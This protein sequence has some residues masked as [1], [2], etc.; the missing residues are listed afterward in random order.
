MDSTEIT[1][2]VI[3]VITIR[4]LVS[5]GPYSGES[6][7]PMYG[8][9]EAQR[10][11]MEITINTPVTEWYKDTPSND[12][13]YWGLDYPPLTAYHSWLCGQ[14]GKLI[15][16][17]WVT[18]LKSRGYESIQHKLFM[19]YSVLVVDLMIYIPAVIMFYMFCGSTDKRK[20]TKMALA[21]LLYP[22]VIL[23]DYG[24]FQYN[25]VSL[26][27]MI[28]AVTALHKHLDIIG[29]TLFCLSLNYKQME[30]YHAIPFFCYLLG[31]CLQKDGL[32]RVIKFSQLGFT[33]ISTF[34]MCWAPF[35]WKWEDAFQVL[36]RL[37]PFARGIYE[38]KV[39]NVWCSLSVIVKLKHVL[40]EDVLI[41]LSLATTLLCVLPSAIDLLFRP[42]FLRFKYALLNCSL[43]FFL[44]SFQVH[45]KSILLVAIPALLLVKEESLAVFVF[46]LISTFSM[47]PLIAKDG[48]VVQYIGTQ[49]LFYI[50]YCSAVLTHNSYSQVRQWFVITNS[51]LLRVI[52]WAVLINADTLCLLSHFISAPVNLPDLYPVLI[53]VFSCTIFIAFVMYFHYKQ[54]YLSDFKAIK[55]KH[56]E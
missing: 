22:G 19:R 54:F 55:K 35:L 40:V 5:Q 41:K 24:H 28:F 18:L 1:V 6:K 13:M 56:I 17:E 52:I 2:I 14:I 11:W 29:S 32:N 50:V 12:L 53:S 8:D 42:T 48:L 10:H 38:D 3:F 36:H 31:Q 15:N 25:C 46:L 9:Y 4:L 26:G 23:I 27:L 37:F 39:S 34:V 45:E 16:E 7:P 51:P 44:F 21:A 33:V 49:M 30:L 47:Y 20:S 43:I